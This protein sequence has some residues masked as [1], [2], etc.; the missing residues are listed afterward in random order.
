MIDNAT[1]LMTQ[2][3]AGGPILR[4]AE[5][6]PQELYDLADG[7]DDAKPPT[8]GRTIGGALSLVLILA[9]GG[10]LFLAV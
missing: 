8:L 10:Y 9:I 5:L 3:S 4:P 1:F 2:N 7:S 6:T